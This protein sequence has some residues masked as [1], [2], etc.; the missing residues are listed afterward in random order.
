[1]K[2]AFLFRGI[3]ID[4]ETKENLDL[5]ISKRI[6]SENHSC[7]HPFDHQSDSFNES[8]WTPSIDMKSQFVGFPSGG[9]DTEAQALIALALWRSSPKK[10][11][12]EKLYALSKF[13]WQ[14]L[15]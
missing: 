7:I 8:Y 4:Q 11:D 3:D 13:I 9:Y 14:G 10:L 12:Y 2:N 6:E 1:M 15:Q 5:R